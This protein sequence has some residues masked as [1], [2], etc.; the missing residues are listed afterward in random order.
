VDLKKQDISD[1][2][3]LSQDMDNYLAFVGTVMNLW[4]PQNAGDFFLV[5]KFTTHKKNL[6]VMQRKNR[7]LILLGFTRA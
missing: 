1:W 4:L 5:H 3:H 2:F 6:V 7:S